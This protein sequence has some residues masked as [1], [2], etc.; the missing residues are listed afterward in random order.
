MSEPRNP[1]ITRRDVLKITGGAAAL[2]TSGVRGRIAHAAGENAKSLPKVPR[3]VLGKTGQEI[4]ILLFGAAVKL[5]TRFDPKL[6]EAYRFGVDYI[7]AADC[8]NGGRCEKA[9]GNFWTRAKIQRKDLWI[10]SKSDEHDPEGLAQTLERGL[11]DLQTSYVDLYFMHGLDE[12]DPLTK[13]M[14]KTAERLKKEGK[15]RYFGFSCHGGQVA[16]LLQAAAERSWIDA[17]MFRYDFSKYGDKK[18]N[19]A[20]DAARKSNVGLIAMKTQRSA[21]SFEPA[22]KKFKRTGKWSKHQAVLKAVWEDDRISAAVSAM[23][24]FEKLKENIAAAIDKTKLTQAERNA[25]E[26]YASATRHLTCDGCEHL[27]NAAAG[28]PVQIG[29]TLRYLMYHD[30]YGEQDKA[31]ALFAKLPASARRWDGVDFT[32][33]ERVCPNG[34]EIATHMRRAQRVLTA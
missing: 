13:D 20:M 3:R 30:A 24:T 11:R 5:D 15:I 7:D 26:A 34:V 23:D 25:L 9:V 27:C 6:A 2:A 14:A 16:E 12:V 1:K 22:W 29:T 32:A 4:P 17:I 18:L 31:R 21:V 28:A 10:T 33:A 8:Y 19:R